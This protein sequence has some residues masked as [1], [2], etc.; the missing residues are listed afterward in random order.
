VRLDIA[1]Q[2]VLAEEYDDV[3]DLCRELIDQFTR[4][5]MLAS[6][7]TALQYLRDAAGAGCATASDVVY[8]RTFL[9]RLKREPEL[10]FAPP[11]ATA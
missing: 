4:A 10:P 6:A 5:G 8:I 7:I 3:V 9:T 2:Q 11:S 1:E